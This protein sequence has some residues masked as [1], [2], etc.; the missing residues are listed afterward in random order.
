[1]KHWTLM[2]LA[3]FALAAPL[4]AQEVTAEIEVVVWGK[5]TYLTHTCP[6]DAS[7][8]VES[9][10]PGQFVCTLRALDADSLWTPA[11]FSAEILGP[12]GRVT[13]TVAD[14]T[15]TVN[16]LSRTGLPGIRVVLTASPKALGGDG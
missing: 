13:A 4:Q 7:G 15:L 16:L 1:M 9:Y 10:A 2:V 8:R 12:Q 3:L 6:L 5:V 11:V 14:S